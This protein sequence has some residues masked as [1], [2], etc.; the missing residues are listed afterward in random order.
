MRPS[1]CP[2]AERNRLRPVQ[3]PMENRESGR[4]PRTKNS[5][6]SFF[7]AARIFPGRFF[8][9]KNLFNFVT[10]APGRR[11]RVSKIQ[12]DC[13]SREKAKRRRNPRP[14]ISGRETLQECRGRGPIRALQE[15]AAA[16][17]Q[18]P[19]SPQANGKSR[20]R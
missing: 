4:L 18:I 20:K 8:L 14:E 16:R 6:I 9:C 3:R 1:Q 10:L 12:Q 17:L 5:S 13:L 7:S 11:E 15:H 19:R 2:K